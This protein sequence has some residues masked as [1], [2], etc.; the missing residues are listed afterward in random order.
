MKKGEEF[1]Y[2]DHTIKMCENNDG[3][4][5]LGPSGDHRGNFGG[6]KLLAM[7]YALIHTMM[8][9]NPLK[10]SIANR[11]HN[12]PNHGTIGDVNF[13]TR[14]Y[15]DEY[16]P[17]TGKLNNHMI[18]LENFEEKMAAYLEEQDRKKIKTTQEIWDDLKAMEPVE[19]MQIYYDAIDVM[20]QYNGR[21][22]TTCIILAMG[23]EPADEEGKW[24]KTQNQKKMISIKEEKAI[25]EVTRLPAYLTGNYKNGNNVRQGFYLS[26]ESLAYLEIIVNLNQRKMK[27]ISLV[28][29]NLNPL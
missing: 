9:I 3:I 12:G 14:H 15:K 6:N 26:A 11:L 2:L 28:R 13:I 4:V 5:L 21:S 17:I 20:G 16:I 24:I 18:D 19:R 10:N 8:N 22:R 25:R 27:K 29:L 23:Y 7:K 1:K